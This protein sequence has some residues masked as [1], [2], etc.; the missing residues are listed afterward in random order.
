MATVIN[1]L[2]KI[3]ERYSSF[4]ITDDFSIDDEFIVSTMNDIRSTLIREE[5][6]KIGYV[7]SEFYQIN[8][9]YEI[10]C[11]EGKCEYNGISIGDGDFSY[12]VQ[13]KSNVSGLGGS[14]ISHVGNRNGTVSFDILNINDFNSLDGRVWTKHAK[15]S[16]RVGD[17]LYL[18][19][20]PT[21]GM[22]YIC[23]RE[24]LE[25]PTT[26]CNWNDNET[27]YPVPSVTKLVDMVLY[28]LMT[29]GRLPSDK[30]NNATDDTVPVK[31]GDQAI[32]M[33]QNL[34]TTN[35]GS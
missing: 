20:L 2:Y 1:I 3:K 15:V 34:Q 7:P 27:E 11:T 19:N 33:Q 32:A 25:D 13:L 9:C 24:I 23:L 29:S 10:E 4:N 26:G 8:C 14:E 5:K 18:K 30:V 22:K 12:H 31:I 35:K 28:R 21:K 16:S 17:R 6:T